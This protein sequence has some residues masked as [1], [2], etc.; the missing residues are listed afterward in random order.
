MYEYFAPNFDSKRTG[1][2]VTTRVSH[3]LLPGN[4][5][6]KNNMALVPHPPYFSLFSRLKMKLKG[7]HF[8]TIEVIEAVSQALLNTLTEHD[9]QDHL[10]IAEEV[11]TVHTCG[12]VMVASRPKVSF[13]PGVRTSPGNYG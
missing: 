8:V 6:S 12:S 10:K 2:C 11:G 4:F 3:F 1:C 5:L 7:H 13:S 9:F